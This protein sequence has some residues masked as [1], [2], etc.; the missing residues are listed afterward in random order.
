MA[1]PSSEA[2]EAALDLV[3]EVPDFPEPGVRYR[4]ITPMLADPAALRAVTEAL[5][6]ALPGGV[7]L[8]AGVEARGFVFAAAVAYSRGLGV[9]PLRKPGKLPKVAERVSYRLE[10]G[11][12]GLELPA[13]TVRAGSRVAIIDDVLAT[14]GTV[15]AGSRLLETAG[16]EVPIVAVALELAGLGGREALAARNVHALRAV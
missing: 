15:R 16:A 5:G 6:A 2:L 3:A 12:G 1:A 4:D 9:L 14:G 10:Y 11:T 8:V 7:D 13:D